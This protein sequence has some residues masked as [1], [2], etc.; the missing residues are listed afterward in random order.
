MSLTPVDIAR[1]EFSRS[2]R[3]YDMGEVRGFLEAVASE[4]AQLQVQLSQAGEAARAAEQQLRSFKDME[5]NLRDAVVTAQQGM[6]ETRQ[7]LE[8]EREAVLA[9]ARLEADR[10]LLE[11]ERH[12]EQIRE[13]IRGMQVQKDLFVERLRFLHNSHGWVLDLM[14]KEPPRVTNEQDTPPA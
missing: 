8:R 6:T 10:I 1:H 12:L 13:Q 2:F 3:G 7:Q 11:G 4:L 9:E 14:E 5:R